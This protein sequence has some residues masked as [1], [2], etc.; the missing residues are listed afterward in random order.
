MKQ[1]AIELQ[2][3]GGAVGN[4]HALLCQAFN[5][6]WAA[7]HWLQGGLQKVSKPWYD[8]GLLKEPQVGRLATHQRCCQQHWH[9]LRPRGMYLITVT[10]L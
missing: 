5:Q 2:Y 7:D 10:V 8:L 1:E 3:S 4:C 9:L 6:L